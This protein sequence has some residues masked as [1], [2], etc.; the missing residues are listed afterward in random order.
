MA[1]ANRYR[2]NALILQWI[3]SGGTVQ[4]QGDYTKF[5]V[6]RSI[7]LIDATAG[8]ALDKEYING[9][10]D[11]SAKLSIFDTANAGTAV[12]SSLVEGTAG[13]LIYG[14]QGTA[15]GKPKWGFQAIVKSH[16]FSEPFDDAV[17]LD[18]EFQKTGAMLYDYGTTF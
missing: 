16:K 4:I 12:A 8:N 11:G 5:D 6:D 3:Y 14:P 10:K 18:A 13:T 17:T 1:I 7:D 2:G 15:T 9:I